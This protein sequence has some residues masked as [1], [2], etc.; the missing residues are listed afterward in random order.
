M[1]TVLCVGDL[2]VWEDALRTAADGADAHFVSFLDVTE[3]LLEGLLPDTIM[4]PLLSANFDA[5][6]LAMHLQALGFSGRYLAVAEGVPVPH[7]IE[8]EVKMAAPLVDFDLIAL[9]DP[10]KLN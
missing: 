4:S 3:A 7:I 5:T 6:D 1:S 2:D 9:P 8:R 10:S